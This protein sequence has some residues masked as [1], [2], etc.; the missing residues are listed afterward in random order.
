MTLG[1]SNTH[2][3]LK[4]LIQLGCTAQ[5]NRIKGNNK[6]TLPAIHRAERDRVLRLLRAVVKGLLIR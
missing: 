4:I 1:G 6:L 2:E 3:Y 5:P